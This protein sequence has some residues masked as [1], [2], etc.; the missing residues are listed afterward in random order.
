[1][2][3]Y[4]H[5]ETIRRSRTVKNAD[6]GAGRSVVASNRAKAVGMNRVRSVADSARVHVALRVV[7]TPSTVER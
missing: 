2:S 5:T 1:V 4:S 3:K 6:A 7:R